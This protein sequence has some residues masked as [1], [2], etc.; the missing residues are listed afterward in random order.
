[1]LRSPVVGELLA[2][3]Y[4]HPDDAC[5]VTELSARLAVSQSTV[6]R[7]ADRLAKADLIL[8]QRRG[9]LRLL[10]ANLDSPLARPLTELLVIS[11][12]PPSVLSDMLATVNGV[13]EAFIYGSWAARCRGEPGPFPKDVD[14]LVVGEADEDDL[15]EAAG[16]AGRQLGRGVNVH[17]V[18]VDVWHRGA[19]SP[20]LVSVR[21]RPRVSIDI[22]RH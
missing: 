3:I 9:N 8:E 16:R 17:R 7:E 5:S 2:W 18:S 14:V 20:F 13:D 12:G 1:M 21:S 4:L 19:D 6:S 22:T 10:R 15:F 11:Y